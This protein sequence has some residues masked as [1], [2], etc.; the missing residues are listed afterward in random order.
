MVLAFLEG[1][2]LDSYLPSSL[3]KWAICVASNGLLDDLQAV[4]TNLGIVHNRIT[5]YNAE[6]DRSFDEIYAH[7]RQAQK[8]VSLLRFPEAHKQAR[9]FALREMNIGNGTADLIPGIRGRDLYEL[10]PRGQSKA[11][12]PPR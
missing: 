1:L 10:I 2:S 6:Y 5:K 4:L 3:E 9:A 11:V 8:F 7:G 12:P